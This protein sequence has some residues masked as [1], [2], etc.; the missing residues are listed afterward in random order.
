M[1]AARKRQRSTK[2]APTALA[3]IHKAPGSLKPHPDNPRMHSDEQ[4]ALIAKAIQEFSFI[5]PVLVDDEDRMLAGHGRVL[6]ATSLGM[7]SIPTLCVTH[8]SD[9]QKKA[10]LVADNKLTERGGWDAAMLGSL[11]VELNETNI[12]LEVLGLDPPEVHDILSNDRTGFLGE[13]D[14]DHNGAGR[15]DVTR[16]SEFVQ[17]N[18]TMSVADRKLII[19]RLRREQQRQGLSTSGEALVSLF[20]ELDNAKNTQKT[21]RARKRVRSGA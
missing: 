11:V 2:K 21:P 12:D 6:A 18:F 14:G 3:I 9:A 4:V 17:L 19:D 20:K 16:V 15:G 5:V 10:F 8:L 7:K 13:G 1:A